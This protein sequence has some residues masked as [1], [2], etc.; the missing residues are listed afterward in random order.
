MLY[1]KIRWTLVQLGIEA[2]LGSVPADRRLTWGKRV[3]DFIERFGIGIVGIKLQT[4]GEALTQRYL[5]RIVVGIATVCAQVDVAESGIRSSLIESVRV[6]GVGTGG[7][8]T[9]RGSG[10]GQTSAVRVVVE[11][12]NQ[13]VAKGSPK[14]GVLIQ[15]SI[16]ICPCY[17]GTPYQR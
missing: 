7:T 8:S 11:D 6:T 16:G 1:L 10:A 14:T 4:L 13:L 3:T 5:Q 12:A 2:I 9:V 17:Y 15:K